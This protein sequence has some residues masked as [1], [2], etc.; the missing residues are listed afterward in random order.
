MR[1]LLVPL[2]D[3]KGQ[4]GVMKLGFAVSR[5]FSSHLTCLFIRPDPRAAIPFMG[6][7]LTA[8]A[9]QDLVEAS[10]REGKGRAA[11]TLAMFEAMRDKEKIAPGDGL[12]RT[13]GQRSHGK[14][15]P[16]LSPTGW[17][18]RQDWLTLP[19]FHSRWIPTQ[20]TQR[21]S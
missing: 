4:D 10:D 19:L 13:R 1:T 11:R 7:G 16:A 14:R 21:K 8:D 5:L 18:G 9:I 3:H 17:A 2:T 15:P 6:E 20:K 12:I